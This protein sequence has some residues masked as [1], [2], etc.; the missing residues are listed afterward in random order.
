[1]AAREV[2]DSSGKSIRAHTTA[3]ANWF[4]SYAARFTLSL[5]SIHPYLSPHRRFGNKGGLHAV[6]LLM[7]LRLGGDCQ[8]RTHHKKGDEDRMRPLQR[9]LFIIP[10]PY[11]I[12]LKPIDDGAFVAIL[13]R[14]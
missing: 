6:L 9:L 14:I 3:Q 11:R 5:P 7:K 8:V 12:T 10:L 2:L 13:T 1:M 4:S